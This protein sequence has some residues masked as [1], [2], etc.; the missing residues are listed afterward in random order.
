MKTLVML[1]IIMKG[2]MVLARNIKFS[3]MSVQ[4]KNKIIF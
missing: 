4:K 1:M 3:R 2:M